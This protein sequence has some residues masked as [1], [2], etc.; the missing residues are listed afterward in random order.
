MSKKNDTQ[1][2]VQKKKVRQKAVKKK[3]IEKR[4]ATRKEAKLE[5]ERDAA[6]EREFS[7]KQ[8]L[9]LTDDEIKKNLEHNMKILQAIN[10][11]A[12]AEAAAKAEALAKAA[13][14]AKNIVEITPETSENSEI[15]TLE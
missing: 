10:E 1:K 5:R 14:E 2:K 11:A 12:E 15:K 8:N 9:G 7:K 3:I 6:F 13:E 4:L